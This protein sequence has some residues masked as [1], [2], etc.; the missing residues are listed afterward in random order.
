MFRRH[1]RRNARTTRAALAI[2]AAALIA[3][4]LPAPAGDAAAA[5]HGMGLVVPSAPQP[6]AAAAAPRLLAQAAA[7][8][9]SVDLTPYAPPAGDQG[10]VNSCAAWATDYTA[11]GYWENKQG[12]AGGLLAPMYTYSQLVGGRNVGTQLDDHMDIAEQQGVDSRADYTQGDYDY[13]TLPTARQ[14]ANA[15]QWRLSGHTDLTVDPSGTTTVTQDSIKAALAAGNPVVIGLEVFTNFFYVTGANHGLYSAV[16]GSVEGYHAVTAL[17]YDATGLRIEN[18]WGTGWGDRGFA[19]L[20]W[21]FVNNYVFQATSV[22]PLVMAAGTPAVVTA[23]GVSGLARRGQTL[24][25][26]VGTWTG[27]PAAFAYQWQRDSGYGF[28]DIAGA[29]TARYTLQAADTG[30]RV[31]VRVTATNGAGSRAA[32]SGAVGPV[33]A[34]APVAL[35]APVIGGVVRRARVL[36]GTLG[37]WTGAGNGYALQWQRDRGYGFVDIPGA[38]SASYAL[39]LAD[40]RARVRL[41]VTAANPDG[42]AVAY[43]GATGPVAADAPAL[44]AAPYVSGVARRGRVLR[45]RGGL[46]T[47]AGNGY[48]FQWQRNRGSGWANIAGARSSRY[49]LRAADVRGHVRLR[50]RILAVNA[51]GRAKVYCRAPRV[52]RSARVSR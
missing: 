19:T 14:V 44:V 32:Y 38:R 6:L 21:S 45:V 16:S 46:W 36:S 13:V 26:G 39:Q 7:L 10:Q 43:S 52:S 22:G 5:P 28:A 25:A 30:A 9:A 3:A 51:D 17:G 15:A 50:L 2:T 29:G 18:Q 42:A 40:E 8:P 47:G 27:A 49:R 20:S 41:R 37:S 34:A 24:A 48:A 1:G 4:A 11:M 31:R 35:A 33:A 12:A 23:P